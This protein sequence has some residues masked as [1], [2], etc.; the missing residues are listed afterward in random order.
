MYGSVYMSWNV[1]SSDGKI[2]MVNK[3]VVIYLISVMGMVITMTK[4]INHIQLSH[5]ISW[6][7]KDIAPYGTWKVYPQY[8]LSRVVNKVIKVIIATTFI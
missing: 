5:S 2:R 3:V 4:A 8:P 7:V 1:S 6:A